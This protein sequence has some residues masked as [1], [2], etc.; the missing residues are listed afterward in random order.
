MALL[1]LKEIQINKFIHNVTLKFSEQWRPLK[2]YSILC[3]CT[4]SFAP[5]P[6]TEVTKRSFDSYTLHGT[7]NGKGTGTGKRGSRCAIQFIHNVTLKFSEQ[8]RP[9][10][11]YSILCSCTSSFA[12]SPV[13]EVTKR[14]FDSYTL[15]GTGNGKGTGT[16]KRGSRCAIHWPLAPLPVLVSVSV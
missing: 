7:G 8:W 5:S 1:R 2:V 12:P 16:G 10:K 13:T 3:S 6:V 4:S 14:S 9:L 15:H 11:V